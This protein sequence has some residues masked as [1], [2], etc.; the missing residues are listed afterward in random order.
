MPIPAPSQAKDDT[1]CSALPVPRTAH[2]QSSPCSAQNMI[3][4]HMSS[5]CQSHNNPSPHYAHSE[6]E[7]RSL[8]SVHP[9]NIT[10]R[11]EDTRKLFPAY[12]QGKIYPASIQ[13]CPFLAHTIYRPA[14][15]QHN[16][17]HAE[18]SWSPGEPIRTRTYQ[19][20]FSAQN[21]AVKAHAQKSS[22][23][24]DPMPSPTLAS[25]DHAQTSPFLFQSGS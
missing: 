15:A 5:P 8:C 1:K 14:R 7:D 10:A 12:A 17:V 3:P 9:T 18:T 21:V 6:F 24:A 20:H 2:C 4:Q 11:A 13:T 22:C 25:R 23:L 19:G 16:Y